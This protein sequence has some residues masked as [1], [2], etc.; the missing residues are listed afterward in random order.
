MILFSW[1]E[2]PTYGAK[3][4]GIAAAATKEKVYVIATRPKV[5]VADLEKICGVPIIWVDKDEKININDHF[6]EIPS[7]YFQAGWY[8]K[9]FIS[10]GSSLRALGVPVVLLSDNSYKPNLRQF[11]GRLYFRLFLNRNFSAVWV[12]GESGRRFMLNNGVSAECIYDGLYGSDERIFVP[13]ASPENREKVIV[14]AGRLVAAKGVEDLLDAFRSLPSD[15]DEWRLE[16]YGN[17]PLL[18][19]IVQTER[20]K[21]SRFV[22]A[23][24]LAK[25]MGAVKIFCLPSHAD[26][27]PLVINEAALTGCGLLVSDA[28]GNSSEFCRLQNSN[29]YRA[30]DIKMLKCGLMELIKKTEFEPELVVQCST[31]LG[32]KFDRSYFPSQFMKIINEVR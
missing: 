16:I 12:P 24:E 26:H 3:L 8:V 18:K 1:N 31:R 19:K 4:I 7:I 23:D 14:F 6:S 15:Y 32:S 11:L 22:S 27:W 30:K 29:I 20:I 10:I 25:R 13:V 21:V 2:L 28:V 9:A 5:P 17:G